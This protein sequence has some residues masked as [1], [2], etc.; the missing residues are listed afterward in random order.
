M[1]TAVNKECE[2]A[3]VDWLIATLDP[4]QVTASYYTGIGNVEELEP[5]AVFV[6][7][8]TGNEVYWNSN[9]WELIVNVSVKEMAADTTSGS[10]GVLAQS[11]QNC[12]WNPNRLVALNTTQSHNFV[13]YQ[14]QNLDIKHSTVKDALINELSVRVVGTLSGSSA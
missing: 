11:V 12:F 3:I 6:S 10:L 14:M 13:A 9:V 1:I 8:D 4:L 7:A 5:P 2:E